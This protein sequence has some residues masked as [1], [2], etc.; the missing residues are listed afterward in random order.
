VALLALIAGMVSY[1]HLHTL[2]ELPGQPGWV[3]ALTPEGGRRRV[4]RCAHGSRDPDHQDA[5][6]GTSRE[7]DREHW[8]ASARCESLDRMLITGERYLR[9]VPGRMR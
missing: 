4:R 1:L 8:I 6:P 9:L 7:R 3:T 2:V 5:C